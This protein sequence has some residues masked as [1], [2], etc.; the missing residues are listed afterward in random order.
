MTEKEVLT[1]VLQFSRKLC[2][3]LD[4]SH[5]QSTEKNVEKI[6]VYAEPSF[7]LN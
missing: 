2:R 7:L 3:S 1:T 6:D 5:M 4:D